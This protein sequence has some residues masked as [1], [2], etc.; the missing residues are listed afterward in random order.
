MQAVRAGH[1]LDGVQE[2]PDVVSPA[3]LLVLPEDEDEPLTLVDV[4]TSFTEM[5]AVRGA[6]S[7]KRRRFA[8]SYDSIVPWKS[9][10]S[11][12]RLVKTATSKSIPSTATSEP[13]RLTSPR[14]CTSGSSIAAPATLAT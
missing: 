14:A 6:C 10:W 3:P 12:V 11:W 9:R 13:K 1:R 2:F 4:E 7:T 8:S 5:A